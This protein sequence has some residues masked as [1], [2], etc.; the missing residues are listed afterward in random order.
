[1]ISRAAIAGGEPLAAATMDVFVGAYGA[2]AGNLA[3]KLLPYGGLYVAGG[4]AAKI[5]PLIERGFLAAFNDKGR[6]APL[7]E[8]VPVHV[9]LDPKVGLIG[10]ARCAAGLL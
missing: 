1:M 2:E 4:I 6:M 3:L 5:L 8:Q 9:V 7:L 10:A